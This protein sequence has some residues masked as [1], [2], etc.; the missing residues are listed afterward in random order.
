MLTS[1]QEL[2]VEV[3]NVDCVEIYHFDVLKP[4]HAET[5]DEFAANPTCPDYQYF[6]LS[7]KVFNFFAVD[8]FEFLIFH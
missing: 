3:A 1:E 2:S 4:S 6:A 8:Y 7:Y 5:F